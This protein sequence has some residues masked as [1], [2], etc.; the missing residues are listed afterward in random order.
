[1]SKHVVIFLV[2]GK[3]VLLAEKK[4]GLGAGY[5]NG[6]GGKVE[7]GETFT[8]AV[9]R[10]CEE[11]VGLKPTN[12]KV[13]AKLWFEEYHDG[14]KHELDVRVFVASDWSGKL[15]ETDEMKPKWFNQN[16]LPFKQMWGDDPYWLPNILRGEKIDGWFKLDKNGQ[17]LEHKLKTVGKVTA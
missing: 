16:N 14:Q 11:E 1:M 7:K 5:W 15:I 17:V 4:R 13:V 9:I 6:P 10:E 8:Q 12:P 3:E 2:K